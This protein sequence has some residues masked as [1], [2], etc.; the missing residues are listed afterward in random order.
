VVVG[1]V[2]VSHNVDY[3]DKLK[4]GVVRSHVAWM[5]EREMHGKIEGKPVGM[6]PL[7]KPMHKG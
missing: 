4:K 6:R 5:W 3:N 7:W 1:I 2:A